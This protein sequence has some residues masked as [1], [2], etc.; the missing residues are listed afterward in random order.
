MGT[1][2]L[3]FPPPGSP[4]LI[5]NPE[6]PR[7]DAPRLV[8]QPCFS[9]HYKNQSAQRGIA[10][11]VQGT[12]RR[13]ER[14]KQTKNPLSQKVATGHFNTTF[15]VFAKNMHSNL[16]LIPQSDGGSITQAEEARQALRQSDWSLRS[17]LLVQHTLQ[18]TAFFRKRGILS[19]PR[20]S[21]CTR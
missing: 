12:L 10:A 5:D 2:L 14:S 4:P 3:T 15:I 11:T 6:S 1:E 20:E 17:I 16:R 18:R 19:E 8:S 9:F 13:S 7:A 21:V